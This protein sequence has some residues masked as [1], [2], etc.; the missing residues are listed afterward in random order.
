MLAGAIGAEMPYSVEC[1]GIFAGGPGS[2]GFVLLPSGTFQPD[3]RSAVT[4]AAGTTQPG[5]G[6]S[7]WF[8][9]TYDSAYAKWLPVP[10]SWVV[11]DGTRY[12]YPG[13][14]GIHVQNVANERMWNYHWA[15]GTMNP[16][17][18]IKG[19]QMMGVDTSPWGEAPR[20]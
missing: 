8:G 13:I 3:P 15:P 1:S 9:S 2:G 12:A 6:Y 5:M 4:V 10:Y 19:F 7:D 18:V 17:A 16:R 20:S 11:P 14:G